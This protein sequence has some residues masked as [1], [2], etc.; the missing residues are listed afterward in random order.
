[1][2]D[3]FH[4]SDDGV[5]VPDD[6]V[7]VPDDGVIAPDDEV[8]VS[9]DTV[10]ATIVEE[11]P[12]SLDDVRLDRVVAL[13]AD[14]SRTVAAD[15]VAGAAVRIDDVVAS[16]GKERVRRGQTLRIDLTRVAG[17]QR[18]LADASQSVDVLH[19]DA[20]VLVINKPVA[21]IVHPGAGHP[22]GTLVNYLLASYPEIAD[23]GDP[24]RPGIVHRLDSGTSGAIVVARSQR[25]YDSLVGQLASRTMS[26]VYRALV[27]GIPS[28]QRGVVD[29]PI[30]RDQRDATKMAVV[31][32]GRPARTHYEVLEVFHEPTAIAHVECRLET[33]RTHQIRVH[34]SSI[35]HPVVGDAGYNGVR[36]ALHADRP[37][38]HACEVAFDHPS[39]GERCTVQAPL[40][41][42]FVRLL[43]R[44]R[45]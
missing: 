39:S 6:G 35:G 17:P 23:V 38:L 9:D 33:G 20:D 4:V 15:L 5:I 42:D 34:M 10:I 2:T 27:W 32:D 25:A 16:S 44:L 36:P 30:G 18:P 21:L 43:D 13:V 8:I 3:D 14:V 45:G 37:M 28:A 7:I 12:A 40:A 1:M 26:R 31:V 11:I 29:A 41:D 19:E 24:L 22:T